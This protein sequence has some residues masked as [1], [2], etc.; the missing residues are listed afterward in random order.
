MPG[1][2]FIPEDIAPRVPGGADTA[3]ADLHHP[4]AEEIGP[5]LHAVVPRAAAGGISGFEGD[6]EVEHGR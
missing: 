5:G 1:L 3:V 4:D 6:A 2:R